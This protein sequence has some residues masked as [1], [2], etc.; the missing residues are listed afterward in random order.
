MNALDQER[1]RINFIQ[2]RHEQVVLQD[3]GPLTCSM[4]CTTLKKII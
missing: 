4:A 1:S 2:V 3:P